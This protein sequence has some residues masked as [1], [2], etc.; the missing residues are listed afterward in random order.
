M[1]LIYN[2]NLLF[3]FSLAP[4]VEI[5]SARCFFISRIFFM[6]SVMHNTSESSVFQ[7]ASGPVTPQPA[8][9][10]VLAQ[11]LSQLS[12]YD[13]VLPPELIA[14]YPPKQ[15]D[16]ARMMVIDRATGHITHTTFSEITQYLHPPDCLVL[17]NTRVLANRLMG[18]RLAADA[19]PYTGQIEVFLLHPDPAD[20]NV[21]SALLRPTRKLQPGTRIALPGCAAQVEVV[22]VVAGTHGRVKVWLNGLANVHAVM[23]AV[24]HMPI[25]PYLGRAADD[26]DKERYQTVYAS[27][28]GAHAAPTAGLHFTPHILQQLAAKGVQKAEVTLSVSTGTFRP[29]SA[30]SIAD[31]AM[32]AEAYDLPQQALNTVL[33]CKKA[34]GRVVAVG[35]TSVKTLETASHNQQGNLQQPE[36][37]WSQLYITPGFDYQVVDAMLTNF[38]LPKSTLL[39]LVSAFMGHELMHKAYA[40]AVEARYRFYSYGDCMLI[41]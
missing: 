12:A 38:H 5:F 13:Y 32:D 34:G 25:P 1:V 29:V 26:T 31:H 39:M 22:E 41:L 16:G 2:N 9:N 21:W 30:D 20:P 4:C 35:T 10:Q 27:Q 36:E 40:E 14:Q 8:L 6:S 3:L 18:H 28:P 37:G 19:T 11:D 24:G 23:A 33:A 7:D 15:R 17:N